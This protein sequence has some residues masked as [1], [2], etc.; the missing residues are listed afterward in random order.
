MLIQRLK[1][2]RMSSREIARDELRGPDHLPGPIGHI[3]CRVAIPHQHL[4]NH[5]ELMLFGQLQ[6]E[7]PVFAALGGLGSQGGVVAAY[8][9]NRG[10]SHHGVAAVADEIEATEL[11]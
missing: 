7:L 4:R 3:S 6:S 9:A 10:R 5:R 2:V 8:G 1:Q 11:M